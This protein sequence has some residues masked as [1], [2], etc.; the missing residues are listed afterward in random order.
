VNK[1]HLIGPSMSVS[2]SLAGLE[3]NMAGGNCWGTLL[4]KNSVVSQSCKSGF[5]RNNYLGPHYCSTWYI[6]KN[7]LECHCTPSCSCSTCKAVPL[8][9]MQAP[10]GRGNIDLTHSWLRHYLEVSSQRHV[11]AVLYARREVPR[12]P[13][14]SEAHPASVQLVPWVKSGRDVTL[15]TQP[16]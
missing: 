3:T 16:V 4:R 11:P 9:A 14:S 6:L 7:N 13:L 10:M 15:T 5:R 8:Q 12:Y 1:V 2:I